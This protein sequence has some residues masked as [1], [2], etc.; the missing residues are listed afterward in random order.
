MPTL[1]EGTGVFRLHL[2]QTFS[3]N[4]PAEAGAGATSATTAQ[5][6]ATLPIAAE[7]RGKPDLVVSIDASALS[8][9]FAR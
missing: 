2:P 6:A 5:T 4:V 8:R 3:V 7:M 9:L 1:A